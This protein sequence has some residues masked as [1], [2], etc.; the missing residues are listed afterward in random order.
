MLKQIA[1]FLLL[2]Q[3][4]SSPLHSH[5][6][7]MKCFSETTP[8]VELQTF[9]VKKFEPQKFIHMNQWIL[10][11]TKRYEHDPLGNENTGPIMFCV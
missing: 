7:Y 1:K 2:I 6:V 9:R 10:N 4:T 5:G 3:S 8:D 11:D